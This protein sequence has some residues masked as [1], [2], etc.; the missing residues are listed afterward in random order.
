MRRSY[1]LVALAV[2]L[3]IA[4]GGE[5][6]AWRPES[7]DLLFTSSRDGNSEIF[8]LRAGQNDW[9]NLTNHKAGDNWPVWSPDGARIAFQS[10]RAGNLDIW[11]MKADGSDQ[12]QLTKDAEPD[13]L[14]AWSPDGKSIVFTSWRKEKDDAK[15]APHLYIMNA[16][17]AGQRRLV[18]ESLNSSEGGSWSPSGKQIVFSRKPGA[19]GADIFVADS[20]GANERRLTSDEADDLYNGSPTFSPDG[21]FRCMNREQ[22]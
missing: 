2:G 18:A 16:E 5:P 9:T 15:R 19:K 4:Q 17:G 1:I 3:A 20:D 21:T 8:L 14:P 11:T 13:Y 7:A 12:V 22:F 10:N 6:A